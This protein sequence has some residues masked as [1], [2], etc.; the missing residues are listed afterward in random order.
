[1][2]AQAAQLPVPAN[3]RLPVV[4]RMQDRVRSIVDDREDKEFLAAHLEILDTPPSPA[5]TAM[6]WV[7][8]LGFAAALTWSWFARID[9]FS[10]ASGRVQP[11]GRSKV[12]QPF[13]TGKVQSILVSN[14]TRVKAGDLLAELESS[15][16][17]GDLQAKLSDLESY[18]AE[19]A[20]RAA[21]M[22]AIGQLAKTATPD[23]PKDTSP[24]IRQR[25]TAVM[26]AEL[27]QYRAA[28]ESFISQI[29]EKAATRNR[30]SSSVASRERLISALR[31]RAEMRETLVAKSAGT[32]AAVIDA[33][34][35]LEQAKTDQAYDSG[36]MQEADAAIESLQRKIEQLTRET[37]ATQSQKMTAA[38][39]QRDRLRG[40]V[41][42]AQVR[43]DRMRLTSPISG[44]VQQLAITTV[45]QV[46]TPA[47]P[48]MV[49][50]PT[51]GPIEIE[52]L[53]Q[54]QDIG[55]IEVGQEATIKVD[56]FPFTRYGTISGRVIRI[57]S[58]AIDQK[59][60]AG[61]T[62][63]ASIAQGQSLQQVSGAPKT[64]NLVFPVT[65]QL[66]TLTIKNEGKET[67]LT[68]GMTA[69]IELKTGRR[70]V[71][72]YLLAP[73]REISSTAMHER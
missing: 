20:R 3:V 47:Q 36:Q 1:M 64:Q 41:A 33:I 45:G 15:D 38:A 39:Q 14:G 42:K 27:S 50:V 25:E 26:E 69:T 71:I 57:S 12:V 66:D 17:G 51:E 35:P 44:T 19:V 60:A 58:D 24:A 4:R 62:D 70:R 18:E 21:E 29:A 48:L 16:S 40:D 13:E 28:R 54:N 23:F 59:D 63:A 5:V 34:Q 43:Y 56:A 37:I 68:A 72:D 55:F 65:V 67:P 49:I 52:A 30:L 2:T 11:S 32:R 73:L 22:V 61:S 6:T 31:E 10:V 7:I 46:V 9:V 53:V 8:C